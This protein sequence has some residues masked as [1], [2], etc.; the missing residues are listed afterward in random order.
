M[1]FSCL[2]IELISDILALALSQHPNPSDI[3]RVNKHFLDICEPIL[4]AHL[5]FTSTHKLSQFVQRWNRLS[6]TACSFPRT[7]SVSLAGGA[8]DLHFFYRLRNVLRTCSSWNR[9][10]GLQ[11]SLDVLSL[12]LHSHSRD[13]HL[14]LIYEA[15]SLAKYVSSPYP[16]YHAR[17]N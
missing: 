14:E 13:P 7:L 6:I 4:Y 1:S 5:H 10:H 3:L 16:T 11:V 12:C 17:P 2:P 8:V 15:L 9:N